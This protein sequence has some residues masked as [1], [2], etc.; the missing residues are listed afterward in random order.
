MS[1]FW[2]GFWEGAGLPNGAGDPATVGLAPAAPCLP[3]APV[4]EQAELASSSAYINIAPADNATEVDTVTVVT[5]IENMD[6]EAD[7]PTHGSLLSYSAGNENLGDTA[8]I[9]TSIWTSH[10][11]DSGPSTPARP[12]FQIEWNSGTVNQSQFAE[13]D[14]PELQNPCGGLNVFFSE[15]P[16]E[17]SGK[18]HVRPSESPASQE[19]APKCFRVDQYNTEDTSGGNDGIDE[20]AEVGGM[21]ADW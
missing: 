8:E 10:E 19:N 1:N 4:P 7:D 13:T 16:R 15:D 17:T 6:A 20:Y 3:G 9:E 14:I 12:V 2:D 18:K 21:A 5:A 11:R